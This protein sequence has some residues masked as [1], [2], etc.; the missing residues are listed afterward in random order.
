M[1][2]K[3]HKWN[4]ITKK[5]TEAA[6]IESKKVYAGKKTNQESIQHLV[7]KLNMNKVSASIYIV[8]FKKMM[9]GKI[10]K[11]NLNQEATDYFLTKILQDYG[12]GKLANAIQAAHEHIKHCTEQN[13]APMNRLRHVVSHHEKILEDKLATE[14]ILV[15]ID[16]DEMVAED[17]ST[18]IYPDEIVVED[19]TKPIYEG[20]KKSVTV[21][22]YERDTRARNKCIA[23]YGCRCIVCD[24]DF[25]SV[26]G[27]IGKD[28]IHVHHL[29]PLADIKKE[30]V[31][32][33]I[34]D[35]VPVCPNCHAMLHGTNPPYKIAELKLKIRKQGN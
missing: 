29:I 20:A 21:N 7:D 11:R 19:Q 26:Y 25:V 32:N 5:D 30:Y 23:H 1:S 13:G 12:V 16:P 33:P 31:V 27:D 14:E 28:F 3:K 35:L 6:Y 24:F 34:K 18:S 2:D 15:S 8:N 4:K 9:A 17:Q 22:A 10:Y